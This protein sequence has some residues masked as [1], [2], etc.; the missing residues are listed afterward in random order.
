MA[1]SSRRTSSWNDLAPCGRATGAHLGN[2]LQLRRHGAEP[3]AR[4]D[5]V[6]P[7]SELS[8]RRAARLLGALPAQLRRRQRFARRRRAAGVGGVRARAIPR[9]IS[10]SDASARA[11]TP[12]LCARFGV[13]LL[14]ARARRAQRA[15]VLRQRHRARHAASL[16]GKLLL[17]HAVRPTTSLR[18]DALQR[19]NAFLGLVQGHLVHRGGGAPAVRGLSFRDAQTSRARGGAE[20]SARGGGKCD[21]GAAVRQV[22]QGIFLQQAAKSCQ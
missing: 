15:H 21:A 20:R 11:R 22:E 4:R 3:P 12:R 1:G 18:R 5:R 9:E 6:P 2:A 10:G 19:G 8:F 7:L 17:G 14:T 16:V 13:L